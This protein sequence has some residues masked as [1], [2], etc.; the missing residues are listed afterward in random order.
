MRQWKLWLVIPAMAL[1]LGCSE[2][3]PESPNGTP[4]A[5]GDVGLMSHLIGK[6]KEQVIAELGQPEEEF[7]VEYG[8][9]RT[10]SAEE[11]QAYLART[12]ERGLVY[13]KYVVEVSATNRVLRVWPKSEWIGPEPPWLKKPSQ[14]N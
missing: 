5:K 7:F 9:P 12:V 13:P 8:Y 14:A 6:T 11:M 3:G 4:S 10:E 2:S 1:A